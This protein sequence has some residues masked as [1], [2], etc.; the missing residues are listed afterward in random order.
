MQ[1]D[2]KLIVEYKLYYTICNNK[3]Y[4]NILYIIIEISYYK[5]PNKY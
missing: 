5:V 2:K 3:N 4:I 1:F